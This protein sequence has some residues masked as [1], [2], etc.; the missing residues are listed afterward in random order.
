M[1]SITYFTSNQGL[2]AS[3]ILLAEIDRNAR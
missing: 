2:H 1:S 3:R